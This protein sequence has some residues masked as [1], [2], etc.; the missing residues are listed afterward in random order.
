MEVSVRARRAIG[1]TLG[2]IALG[3]AFTAL[4]SADLRWRVSEQSIAAR[5][6]ETTPLGATE[7][8][9]LNALIRRNRQPSPMWRGVIE[10]GSS[11]P[12]SARGGA[13]YTRVALAEYGIV[14]K[15]SVEAFYIFDGDRRLVEVGIRKTTDAF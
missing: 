2:L 1:W 13:S 3:V 4:W 5:E 9:V 11:Y 12:V 10:P 8:A 7:T 14:F 15:T 6:L